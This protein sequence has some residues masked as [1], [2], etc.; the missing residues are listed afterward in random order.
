M[1]KKRI[2]IV[3]DEPDLLETI[4]LSLEI[5]GYECLVAYDGFRGFER[6]R[7]EK[8]D[9]IILDVMLPGMNGYKVCRLLK[10]DEKYKHIP[11]IM[12]TAEA[13]EK[14]RL[15]GKQTGADFYMTK[16]FSPDKLL[17]KVKE[18]LGE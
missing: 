12:L 3:D 13:Q 10:F 6:A 16:P 9:L 8:P 15:T 5:E 2:L 7:K 14:D 4:Q 18:Y 17:V 1:P 11:I